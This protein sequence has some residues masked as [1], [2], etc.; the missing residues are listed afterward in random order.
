MSRY[1]FALRPRWILSHL[2]VLAMVVAMIAAGFWQLD[3][4]Q[5]KRDRNHEIVSRSEQPTKEVRSLGPARD[6]R[7]IETAKAL[8]YRQATATGRYL[9][10]EEVLAGQPSKDGDPG[11]WV[12]T[13]LRL[14]D[15]TIV[16]VN[17]GWIP[18]GGRY[19]AVPKEYR[20]PTGEVTVTGLVMASEVR[21]FIGHTDPPTGHLTQLARL[22]VVRLDR[23]VEGHLLPFYLQLSTQ[24]PAV[25]DDDPQPADPPELSEGPHLSYAIQWFTFTGLTLIV[26]PLI[27]R[28][29]AADL[30][31]EV[32]DAGTGADPDLSRIDAP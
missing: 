4:L 19:Q 29:K 17:R 23:Q 7:S 3:R 30:E 12:L 27:L 13:P 14:D 24:R 11:A 6:Y 25:R 22:D 28:K 18:N 5:Q 31:K 16:A 21:G 10:D 20:A 26:Y 15:G 2:F 8:Q 32:D 9:P 1:R